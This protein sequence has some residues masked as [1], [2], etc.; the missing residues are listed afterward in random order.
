MRFTEGFAF[1]SAAVCVP[2]SDGSSGGLFS[3]A[4]GF[5]R[6]QAGDVL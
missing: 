4:A 3:Q 5:E 6:E 1:V 2:S